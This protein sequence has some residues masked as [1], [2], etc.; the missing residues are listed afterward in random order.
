MTLDEEGVQEAQEKAVI[1]QVELME[2]YQSVFTNPKGKQVLDHLC[3]HC[4]LGDTT[5][6]VGDPYQTALN[7]G[8]RRVILSI[9]S[10]LK[11][12][13]STIIYPNKD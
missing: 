5:F 13:F 3:R 7:E 12:D 1:R 10:I 8:S 6:V 2:A 11:K 9:L 4:F